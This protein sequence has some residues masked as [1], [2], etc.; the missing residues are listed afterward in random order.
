MR[1]GERV[2]ASEARRRRRGWCVREWDGDMSE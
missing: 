1:V 2:C